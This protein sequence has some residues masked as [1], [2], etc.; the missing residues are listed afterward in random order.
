MED[1]LLQSDVIMLHKERV[2]ALTLDSLMIFCCGTIQ[3][4]LCEALNCMT[5][6][7]TSH[8]LKT[9]MLFV[10]FLALKRITYHSARFS[11]QNS[12]D[13]QTRSTH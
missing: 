9:L 6:V 1:K 12:V 10:V 5:F 3:L 4:F 2:R 8:I 11:M 13:R 7:I